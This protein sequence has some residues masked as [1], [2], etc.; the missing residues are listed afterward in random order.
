MSKKK[1]QAPQNNKSI[2]HSMGSLFEMV[3]NDE[4]PLEKAQMLL[5]ITDRAHTSLRIE[6]ERS[7]VQHIINANK[8][9]MREIETKAF[10]D[11][12]NS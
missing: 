2:F 1:L 3:A 5:N 10:D 9:E 11:T 7:K 8:A 12:L 6:I 4:M